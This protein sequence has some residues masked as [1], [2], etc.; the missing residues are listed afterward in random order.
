MSR[1]PQLVLTLVLALGFVT[2]ADDNEVL[3][4]K[5][6]K[7][8]PIE[9]IVKARRLRAIRIAQTAQGRMHAAKGEWKLAIEALTTAETLLKMHDR[10]RPEIK[11][12]TKQVQT[13]IGRCYL[14]WAE[15]MLEANRDAKTVEVAKK[16]L[17]KAVEYDVELKERVL[18][19]LAEIR[20]PQRKP[21]TGKPKPDNKEILKRRRDE[22]M[23]QSLIAAGDKLREQNK[24]KE[25]IEKYRQAEEILKRLERRPEKQTTGAQTE[26]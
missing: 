23:A 19:I 15:T 11:E 3:S 6:P 5:P 18:E 10:P 9:Q 16:N 24:Y 20:R 7:E 17:A 25:A 14:R 22:A 8:I 4:D 13:D 21:I 12:A 26:Q 2:S 1:L